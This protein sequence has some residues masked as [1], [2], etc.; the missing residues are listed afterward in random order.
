MFNALCC[1][2]TVCALHVKFGFHASAI[3]TS[4]ALADSLCSSPA[5][6][7]SGLSALSIIWS[8]S[9]SYSL[10]RPALVHDCFLSVDSTSLSISHTSGARFCIFSAMSSI[11][12]SSNW[13]ADVWRAEKCYPCSFLVSSQIEFSYR[14][15]I[16]LLAHFS[17]SFDLWRWTL[18]AM[19][20]SMVCWQDYPQQLDCAALDLGV[21]REQA[22]RWSH[23]EF[24]VILVSPAADQVFPECEM[25][26][27]RPSTLRYYQYCFASIAHF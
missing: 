15:F 14:A 11:G 22:A 19:S 9:R 1:S 7:L 23:C 17:V 21:R 26:R 8:P 16:K 5:C 18:S 27:L 3:F 12:K 4:S 25:W 2:V 20:I 6:V 10:D 24:Q 13:F